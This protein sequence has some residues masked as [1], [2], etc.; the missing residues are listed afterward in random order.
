[1][2]AVAIASGAMADLTRSTGGTTDGKSGPV[3]NLPLPRYVS[4]KAADGNVRRGPALTQRIDWV[5][6]RRNMPLLVT[7]DGAGGWVHYALLSGV[8]TVI[9]EKDMLAL[10]TRPDPQTPVVAALEL[11]VVARLG[12]CEPDWCRISAGGYRGWAPKSKLW[13]VWPGEVRD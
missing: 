6:M 11:G 12:E 13:G 3:T 2:V 4:M 5:F 9:V 1:M 7:A 10:R 8:R